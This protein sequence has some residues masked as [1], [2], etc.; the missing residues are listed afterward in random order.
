MARIKKKLFKTTPYPL[1]Y[2]VKNIHKFYNRLSPEYQ[3]KGNNIINNH[4]QV[5]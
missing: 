4:G 3:I 1:M 2:L 5:N